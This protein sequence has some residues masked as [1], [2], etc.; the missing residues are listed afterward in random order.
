M[1]NAYEAYGLYLTCN[2]WGL[3]ASPRND[4]YAIYL[5]DVIAPIHEAM[6]PFI[7]EQTSNQVV[8]IEII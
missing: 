5:V 3:T 1:A 4:S 7:I 2:C 6:Y 8:R